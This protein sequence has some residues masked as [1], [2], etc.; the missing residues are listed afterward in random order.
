[1]PKKTF[2]YPPDSRAA[3]RSLI[4][5]FPFDEEGKE[6]FC[7]FIMVLDEIEEEH[8]GSFWG[9]R[10]Y[11]VLRG[12]K[13]IEG[14]PT[15]IGY[16]GDQKIP[17]IFKVRIVTD[18]SGKKPVFLPYSMTACCVAQG[19]TRK[20]LLRALHLEIERTLELKGEQIPRPIIMEVDDCI[21]NGDLFFYENVKERQELY[22][23]LYL[24][25]QKSKERHRQIE[26]A[27]DN[28]GR[29]RLIDWEE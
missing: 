28:P 2:E 13:I 27:F 14:H 12:G 7:N 22:E 11:A 5:H 24:E 21:G 15:E 19:T 29:T 4:D 20:K 16:T 6:N 10:Q 3:Y 18:K 25:I 17:A 1:M 8:N 9:Y 26:A 23:S